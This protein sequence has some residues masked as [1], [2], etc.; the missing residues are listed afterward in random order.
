MSR[1]LLS[2]ASGEAL[3]RGVPLGRLGSAGDMGGAALYLASP[4]GSWMTGQILVVDG[5]TTAQPLK[6]TADDEHN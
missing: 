4:A 6:M 2:Y 1:G 3:A 5:G